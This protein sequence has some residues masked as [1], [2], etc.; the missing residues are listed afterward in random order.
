MEIEK[1]NIS[2][3]EV[4]KILGKTR[5]FVRIGIQRGILPFGV[6]MKMP[7][8]KNY[9]YHIAPNAFYDYLKINQQDRLH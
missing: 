9:T 6:A 1:Q 3:E 5:Q 2:I 7:N 8:R 4:A